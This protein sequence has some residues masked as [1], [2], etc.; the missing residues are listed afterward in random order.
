MEAGKVGIYFACRRFAHEPAARLRV[1]VRLEPDAGRVGWF[2][3]D[4]PSK[5]NPGVAYIVP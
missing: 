5:E 2:G 4:F 3:R 1:I